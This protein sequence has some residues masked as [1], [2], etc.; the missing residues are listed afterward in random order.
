VEDGGE[1]K[2]W[3]VRVNSLNDLARIAAS[4]VLTRNPM[5]VIRFRYE[6]LVVYSM[7]SIIRDYYNYYGVPLVYYYTENDDGDKHRR[8]YIMVK[9]DENGEETLLSDRIQHGYAVIPVMDLAEPPPF[10]PLEVLRGERYE[11]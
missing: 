1:K 10:F 2:A 6:G 8:R 5:Y 9:V 3:A 11:P 7:M 4:I